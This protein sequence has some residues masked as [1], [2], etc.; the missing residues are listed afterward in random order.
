MHLD[1]PGAK[2][3]VTKVSPDLQDLTEI[4]IILEAHQDTVGISVNRRP[5]ASMAELRSTLM[6][7]GKIRLDVPIVIDP[8]PEV[9]ISRVIEVYDLCREIGFVNIQFATPADR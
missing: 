8:S 5:V 3:A 9:R 6:T 1:L 7:L 2:G 4:V